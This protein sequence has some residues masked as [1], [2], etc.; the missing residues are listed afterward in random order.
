[1]RSIRSKILT[2]VISGLVVMTTVISI[3]G[4]STT[5]ELMHKDAD[6]ILTN[7]C[8]MEAAYINDTLG[9]I[10]KSVEIMEHYA[11]KELDSVESLKEMEYRVKYLKNVGEMFNE[12]AVNTDGVEAFFLRLNPEYSTYVAGFSVGRDDSGNGFKELPTTDLS[13]YSPDD[14]ENVGWYYEPIKAKKGIWVQPYYNHRTDKMII[15]YITPFYVNG[16]LAGVIGMDIDFSYMVK[17]VNEISVYEDGYAILVGEDGETIH[18]E[19]ELPEEGK[20]HNDKHTAAIV[21]LKNGMSLELVADYKD[22]QRDV[23]PILFKI[24]GSFIVILLVFCVYAF[25]VTRKI[26][27]P[28]KKLTE[29]IEGDIT[30]D[31]ISALPVDSKDEIGVLSQAFVSAYDRI[32]E[33]TSYIN[34]LAYRDT[35][36]GIKNRAAYNE[37]VEEIT[38]EINVGLPN[39]AL[40]VADINFLK[41]TNDKYGHD[42]GNK[43]IIHAARNI[44]AAFKS[45]PV[46]RIGGDEFVVILKGEDLDNYR[47]LIDKLDEECAKDH[48]RVK[49]DYI[50]VSVARG[51]ATYNPDVDKVFDDVFRNADKLMY[52]H[53]EKMKGK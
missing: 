1:M 46:F 35:L 43:L 33:Y 17:T 47:K 20:D 40:L 8:K 15:S 50:P 37:A 41:E 36:T 52:M 34:A 49:G 30:S 51:V 24:I 23:R 29:L 12:V 38:K 27:A 18:N 11:R 5:H 42:I 48:I 45:S 4:F 25:I 14:F 44:C 53:K 31:D 10:Q 26:T 13:N 9:D 2:V 22:I 16:T 39:F 32:Q 21:I 28:I 19:V 6:R 3:V 7:R